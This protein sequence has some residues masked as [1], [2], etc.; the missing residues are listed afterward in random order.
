[1]SITDPHSCWYP[2]QQ[3]ILFFIPARIIWNSPFTLGEICA[4]TIQQYM[5]LRL[6]FACLVLSSVHLLYI[7]SLKYSYVKYLVLHL[8]KCILMY[9]HFQNNSHYFW[10][11]LAL[12]KYFN[13]TKTV[14]NWLFLSLLAEYFCSLCVVCIF[15]ACTVE[16]EL[17]HNIAC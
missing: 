7:S 16:F 17:R 5:K 3:P 8:Y 13:I 14:N 6:S 11:Q 15:F 10:L 12:V 9:F 1:M 2:Y 4:W